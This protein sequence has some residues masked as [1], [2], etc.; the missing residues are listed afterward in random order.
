MYLYSKATNRKAGSDPLKDHFDMV[1]SLNQMKDKKQIP[2][3]RLDSYK[4]AVNQYQGQLDRASGEV[5]S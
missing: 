1:S 5:A 3:S 4:H 2:P